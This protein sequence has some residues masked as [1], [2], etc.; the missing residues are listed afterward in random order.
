MTSPRPAA[1]AAAA[2]SCCWRL[3]MHSVRGHRVGRLSTLLGR[4]QTSTGKTGTCPGEELSLTRGS[5]RVFTGRFIQLKQISGR[6]T[7]QKGSRLF[8]EPRQANSR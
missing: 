6:L 3:L 8:V 1:A 7:G 2:A 4:R 5:E